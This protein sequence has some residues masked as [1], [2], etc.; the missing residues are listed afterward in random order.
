MR[1]LLSE[2]ETWEKALFEKALAGHV[3]I[4][5]PAP[6]LADHLPDERDVEAMAVFVNSRLTRETLAVFSNLKF[7]ATRS[8]GFDHIDLTACKERGILVANV[9]SYGEHTV[10]E[11][12]F[13]LLLE[14][15]R[16]VG[17]AYASTQRFGFTLTDDMRGQDLFGKVMA[18]VGT[19]R[20][21]ANV[22]QIARGFGLRVLCVDAHPNQ[23]LCDQGFGYC[24]LETALSEADVITFHVPALPSTHHLLNQERV[25]KLKA[26][27]FIVNTSRGPVIDTAAL[28]WGLKQKI[29]AGAAL[30]VLEEEGAL[31]HA[32]DLGFLNTDRPD[33]EQLKI[34]LEDE[35][36]IN[37]PQVIITPHNAFNTQEA[38]TR[39]AQT[40]IDNIKAFIEG[41]A[42]N[43]VN[44]PS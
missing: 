36:L 19:G 11:Y 17:L 27:V 35:Y 30:D 28:I 23:I 44:L 25:A 18:V 20:I 14:I 16:K 6:V 40:S 39:I 8:T 2:A 7:I 5:W 31:A 21:G 42:V 38:V 43:L 34:I 13:A 26:G 29:I 32:N 37:H 4:N 3:L 33:S 9:P 22:A 24:D 10:A 15:T 1:I 12:T 41:K